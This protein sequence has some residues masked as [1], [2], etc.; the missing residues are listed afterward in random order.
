MDI[1]RDPEFLASLDAVQPKASGAFAAD[2]PRADAMVL[3]DYTTWQDAAGHDVPPPP[4]Y[5]CASVAEVLE[6]AGSLVDHGSCEAAADPLDLA[7]G[8]GIDLSSRR[9]IGGVSPYRHSADGL[10]LRERLNAAGVDNT[11]RSV[12]VVM[13]DG[14]GAE[15]LEQYGSYAPFLKKATS[16][17]VLD[18]AF[19]TTTAA[20]LSSFGTCLAP[21]AH[22]IVG[23]DVRNPATG[24]IMNHLSG[25]PKEIDPHTWQ[26]LPTVMERLSANRRV[27][28]ISLAKYRGSG[29][30]E[31]SLRGGEFLGAQGV[32][33]RITHAV[34]L[35]NSRTPTLVYLYWPELDQ[36]GHKYGAGSEQWLQALQELDSCLKRLAGR[37]PAWAALLLTADHGMVNV[38]EENRMD[39]TERAELWEDI[40]LSAGEPRAVHLYVSGDSE[41][42]KAEA[43]ERALATWSDHFG[44]IAWVLDSRQLWERGYFGPVSL[45]WARERTGDI[46]VC[47]R[48]DV[49][50]YDMR[51]Y[52]PTALHMVGQHGS[53]TEAERKIP[54]LLLG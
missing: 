49:A 46:M 32:N 39:I 37:I 51:H 41:R 7:A 17:G 19:P 14:L 52:K 54:L 34:E 26:P 2:D 28:T 25:W 40:E 27:V 13:V 47:A 4:A 11:F 33:A 23:Y 48:E 50:L 53:L 29:L 15:L 6:S 1:F 45:G 10:N 31:A 18:A 36:A 43:T 16:L 38:P 42:A 5:G 12:C 20:S 9:D 30:T 44:D 8:E 22:G 35:L 3:S 24:Q 21:G